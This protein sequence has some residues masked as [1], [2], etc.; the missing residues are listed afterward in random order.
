[1]DTSTIII[2]IISALVSGILGWIITKA[3]NRM[4]GKEKKN[5]EILLAYEKRLQDKEKN[6]EQLTNVQKRREKEKLRI[7]QSIKRSGLSTTKIVEKYNK[8]LN[9]IIIGYTHQNPK[10]FIKEA[11]LTGISILNSLLQKRNY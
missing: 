6:I 2:I 4:F 7:L 11:I 9:A 3:L 1:M 5:Q 8:P 10:G